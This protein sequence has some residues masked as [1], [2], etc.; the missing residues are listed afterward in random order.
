MPVE[1]DFYRFLHITK[2]IKT[3]EK[4]SERYRCFYHPSSRKE[5]NKKCIFVECLSTN[6]FLKI[7]SIVIVLRISTAKPQKF[8]ATKVFY[9]KVVLDHKV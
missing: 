3:P 8:H 9:L 6:E 4:L 2:N 1:I 7:F 5:K